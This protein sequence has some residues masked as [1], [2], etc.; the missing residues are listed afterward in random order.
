MNTA[1]RRL[2]KKARALIVRAVRRLETM[3]LLVFMNQLLPIFWEVVDQPTH[4]KW[5]LE[6]KAKDLSD[7]ES[8][9]ELGGGK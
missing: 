6:Q 1:Q 3:R 5:F 4:S 2:E 9:Y 8:D 7:L